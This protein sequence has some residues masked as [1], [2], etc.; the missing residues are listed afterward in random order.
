VPQYF[1]ESV[2]MIK[3]ALKVSKIFK[4][5]MVWNDWTG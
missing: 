3:L 1:K 4:R 5:R 2:K